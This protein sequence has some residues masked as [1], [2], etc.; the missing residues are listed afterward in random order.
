MNEKIYTFF[1]S[2]T[3]RDLIEERRIVMEAVVA[4]G[5]VPIGMEY[6]PA[7][8]QSQFEYI[9]S[10][11]DKSD[12]FILIVAGKYGSINSQTKLSYTEM[13]YDYAIDRGK[14]IAALLLNEDELEK[15]TVQ[16]VETDNR[17]NKMLKEFRKKVSAN[18]M[19]KMFSD[20]RDL[21]S[22]MT[23]TIDNLIKENENERKG[24]V[25][26]SAFRDVFSKWGLHSIYKHRNLMHDDCDIDLKNATNQIDILCYGLRVFRRSRNKITDELLKKGVNFR[27]LTMIPNSP[28][29]LQKEKE[30]EIIKGYLSDI[31]LQLVEWANK[32]NGNKG[33]I[34]K[35]I[36]KGY[37]CMPL[38][39][40]W[41]IDDN[42]YVS[43]LFFG[44]D[45]T[46][47]YKFTKEG[48]AFSIYT[49]YFDKLW[50]NDNLTIE[51]TETLKKRRIRRVKQ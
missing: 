20:T 44:I 29:V 36:V 35:I 37:S 48:D 25:R 43:T 1:V 45:S 24:W 22:S 27:I 15:L 18:R 11:I 28:F 40:Y 47:S 39:Y 10:L 7:G 46:I 23:L 3:Y 4:T 9:K 31:I 13:E 34:G 6:F 14:P 32:K 2:S 12:F 19:C 8:N 41:R 16:S 42:V 49:E 50:S 5:N 17:K 33:N 21:A 26:D 30:D 51:L 38:G